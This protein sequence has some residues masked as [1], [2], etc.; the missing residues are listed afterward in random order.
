MTKPDDD[1]D[2][3]LSPE[4]L[5]RYDVPGAPADFAARVMTRLAAAEAAPMAGV[6]PRRWRRWG[7][8][9]AT[10]MGAA[11][12]TIVT[13]VQH[14]GMAP[15]DKR[16]AEIVSALEAREK[17]ER[18]TTELEQLDGKLRQEL[19]AVHRADGQYALRGKRA[20]VDGWGMFARTARPSLDHDPGHD[21]EAY[22]RIDD[23]PFFTTAARP[24][25]TFS[26]DVDTASY[27][28]TRRFLRDGHLPPPDAVR[29][30]ELI[31]YF[32]Y[33]YPAPARGEPFSITTDVAASPWNPRFRIV[34]IGLQAPRIDD[35]KVPARNLVFLLDVSGS[36]ATPDKLPLLKQAL[37]MLVEQLRPQDKVAIAVYAGASGVALPASAGDH[38]DVI[39]NAI[40]RLEPGGSTNGAAG[41]RLAYDLAEAGAIA[42]G[43]N[44]VILCTDGDFNVGVTSEGELTRLIEAERGRGV[45]LTVLGFGMGNLK[46]ATMEK[47]ADRGNGNYGRG[48]PA[49]RLRKPVAARRGLQRRQEGTRATSAP[50]TPSRPSTRSSP[51][52]STSRRRSSTRSSIRPGLP[53]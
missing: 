40:A 10:T 39:R 14:N 27:A 36:M 46:D 49:H 51:P 28:N 37:G 26:V 52:A 31:N 17:V 34:R 47:L 12:L 11:A 48:L 25:S 3:V 53:R 13:L 50:A 21:T 8:L 4:N 15:A 45:F 16:N 1:R 6:R 9:G 7:L 32:H 2:G 23:S 5:A 42:G 24:L 29:I 38:K 43:I 44:R 18:V 20:P 33:D 22:A 19:Q 35:A 30:E 41:I